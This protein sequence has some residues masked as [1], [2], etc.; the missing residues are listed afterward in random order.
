[1]PATYAVRITDAARR[2][3]QR[4]TAYLSEQATPAIARAVALELRE[5]ALSLKTFPERGNVPKELEDE[6]VQE[7]R[8]V[9]RSP[10]RIFYQ[11]S[12]KAVAIVLI[13]DGRRD[14]QA[15]LRS[16]VLSG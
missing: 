14:M 13:A 6:G 12:E 2:D 1:M 4:I 7:F 3:L 16:R 15:L 10:H 8:Q 9:V 5:L 11:F